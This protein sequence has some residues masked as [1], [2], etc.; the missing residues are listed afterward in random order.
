MTAKLAD[1]EPAEKTTDARGERM[2]TS[3]GPAK[4]SSLPGILEADM[5]G[6]LSM[7]SSYLMRT[8]LALAVL[9]T[10]AAACSDDES[11]PASIQIMHWWNAGGE[12]QA[13]DALIGAFEK[14][15]P[16]IDVVDA[17]VGGGSTE[18]R[19]ALATLFSEGLLPDTFQANGGWS[20]LTWV[21]YDGMDT[22]RRRQIAERLGPLLRPHKSG[23]KPAADT[24]NEVAEE[25]DD[26]GP[27]R[28]G[29]RDDFLD[30]R[31]RHPR[32][33]RVKVG[34]SGNA[35]TAVAL[36]PPRRCDGI[37]GHHQPEARLN[38][39]GVGAGGNRCR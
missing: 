2:G 39:K 8:C 38:G 6:R 21:L 15:H 36:R 26:V 22:E 17:S 9:A 7:R 35:E 33:A 12:K 27:E 14:E 28:V 1:A 4:G 29:R 34:E 10:G 24:G 18:Q 20:L 37:A 3:L 16:S 19:L 25:H 13:I 30:P 31:R 11:P 32:L 5:I 23:Q